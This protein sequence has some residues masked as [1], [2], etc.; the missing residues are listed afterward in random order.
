[1]SHKTPGRLSRPPNPV[2]FEL[3]YE[4]GYAQDR[5]HVLPFLLR[6]DAAHVVMLAERRL[7]PAATASRLLRVNREL[8]ARRAAGEDLFGPPPSHRG[9]YLLYENEYVERLGPEVGGTAHLARSRNDINATVYRFR[10]RDAVLTLATAASGLAESQLDL[11]ERHTETLTSA[12]TH[13]QPAQPS[14]LA[15]YLAGVLAE[16]MRALETLAGSLDTIGRCP[17]GA[18]AGF[19]TSFPVDRERVAQLLGFDT[20]V[21]NSLDA[22][23]SRD[24][25]VSVLAA[26]AQLGVTLTRLAFDLQTWG[27]HAYGFVD[28]PD[29]LVSTSSI[30]PQKRNAYVLENIRGRAVAPVGALTHALAG[31]KNTPFSNSVEAGS[32][33]L[34]PLWGAL[35]SLESAVRLTHLLVS[36]VEVRP[37]RMQAF[38]DGA[39]TTMTA[40][41]DLLVAGHGIAFRTAHDVV[42]QLVARHADAAS[43]PPAALKET[44]EALLA[45]AGLELTLDGARLSEALSPRACVD[46]ALHGGGPAPGPVRA[47]LE[48][49]RGRLSAL[50]DALDARQRQYRSADA[51]LDRAVEAVQGEKA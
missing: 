35:A 30:M 38:L 42:G 4:P 15:H 39:A 22:V 12:F 10:L 23:A 41:A 13:M 28:W 6:I 20:V 50:T 2:L 29:D 27:S 19:G 34:A 5:V 49:L 51:E 32:E 17:M 9:L 45:E 48:R 11:A 43:L 26:A 46:A 37:E 47:Q 18:A 8:A 14:T 3:L 25:A 44:L 21:D 40:V 33:S 16:S 31:V 24:Y 1:M 36:H 7:L